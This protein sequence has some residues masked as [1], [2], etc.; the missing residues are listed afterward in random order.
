M[1]GP[2][3]VQGSGQWFNRDRRGVIV[4]PMTS[5]LFK[6]SIHSPCPD[7]SIQEWPTDLHRLTM[8]GFVDV[9]P[10]VVAD[11]FPTSLGLL[12]V[13]WRDNGRVAQEAVL[14][15]PVVPHHP[16]RGFWPLNLAVCRVTLLP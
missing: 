8:P 15:K 2:R 4:L 6:A 1:G 11:C 12:V 3:I 7:G 10:V 5:L 14:Q 16:A 9:Q 13:R